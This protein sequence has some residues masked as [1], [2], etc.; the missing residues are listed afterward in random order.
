M[1]CPTPGRRSSTSIALQPRLPGGRR[2]RGR[3]G[4]RL[5]RHRPAH[6]RC[7]RQARHAGGAGLRP[8]LRRHLHPPQ[9]RRRHRRRSSPTRGCCTR[10]EQR[11]PHELERRRCRAARP[12]APAGA[13]SWRALRKRAAQR[14]VRPDR[15]RAYV[16]VAIFAPLARALRRGRD[17]RPSRSSPGASQ[18]L[19]GTDQLG[20]DMLSRLIYGARNTIGIALAHHAPRPSPRRRARACSPRSRRLVDQL[21]SPC[22]D[23]LMAI[24]TL[25]FALVLLV[26]PRL[27]GAQPRS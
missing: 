19:L 3:G 20:R 2:G 26:D 14:L 24:P 4:V 16:I 11:R 23:V 21:L 5:S 10:D 6:G 25:I 9:P 7:R 8:D 1:R 17:G 18:F 22:V 15:H 12:A 27:V 13:E